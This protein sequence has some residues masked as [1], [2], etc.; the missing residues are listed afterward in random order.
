MA[1]TSRGTGAWNVLG[2]LLYLGLVVVGLLE[3]WLS[4]FFGMATDGCH[5][6]AC[7]A[8]YHVW[9]AMIVVWA[10]VGAV[11]VLTLIAMFRTSSRGKVVFGWP[12][13]GLLALGFVYVTADAI[14]H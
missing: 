14:L 12:F 9:P 5:D 3:I 4:L 8:S 1:A 7:D 6:A 13:A 11:L 10:G 2:Y